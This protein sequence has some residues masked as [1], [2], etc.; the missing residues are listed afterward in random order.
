MVFI[1]EKTLRDLEFNL[2]IDQIVPF[3]ISELGAIEIQKIHPINDKEERLKALYKVDEYLSSFVNENRIPNHTFFNN[4]DAIHLLGIE[5]TFIEAKELLEIEANL[6]TLNTLL[7]FFKKFKEIYPVLYA[8]S[9]EVIFSKGISILINAKITKYGT[10][11]DNASSLLKSIRKEIGSIRSQIGVSFERALKRYQNQHYLD[12]IKE[13]VVE[14]KRVL[15]VQAM[16][17]KK[18]N[19]SIMG[20]SK[21]GSIVFIAPQA[22]LKFTRELQHLELEEKEEVI[23]IL[24]ELT[25]ELR[26]YRDLFIVHQQYLTTLDVV[27]A[28]AKYAQSINALL[29]IITKE[30]KIFLREAY[31]PILWQQNNEKNISTIPQTIELNEQQQIIV[32]SGPNAGGKSIT[33]KT[34][35]L[36]QVMLQSGVL[37]PVHEKSEFSF[38]DTI[39]TDI[40]DNQSIENQ[41]STYS[42]RLKNMQVFL[43]KCND[44]TLFL[45]DEFGTGSDPEL[46]GA[47]AEIFL[48][49]FYHKKSFGVITTHYANLKALADELEFAVN[50]NMQFDK[51]SLAPLFELVTGQAGSSFTFEVARQNGIPYSLINRAKKKVS[52][53]KVRLDKTISKLQTERNKLQR[54]SLSLEKEKDL[55]FEKKQELSNK[56]LRVQD[57]LEQFQTLYDSNQKM[58]QYGRDINELINRYFQTNNKKQLT[59]EF[60]KWIQTERVKFTK[61]N[62]PKK[63]TRKQKQVV[64]KIKQKQ[65][66][67]LK[68]TEKE[69]LK[70][71]K[72]VRKEKSSKEAIIA[73]KKAEYQFKIGD[74]V[75]LIDGRA[76]GTI[77]RVQRKKIVINYGIFTTQAA[78]DQIELVKAAK[79]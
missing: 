61:K 69:V 4:S 51:R 18:V 42:Y 19:G 24:K 78:I 5:N 25:D 31:H 79:P 74:V 26:P 38:F 52:S 50:A 6:Q 75:R 10:V 45:I 64:E 2:V 17:R 46:G 70:A 21:T 8:N 44:S 32:I 41:L 47:L 30:K 66:Q 35:G 48:E 39:L 36:L 7:R 16:H 11:S 15:A 34:I 1:T 55:A 60:N 58:L 65:Q 54:K 77:E 49:E 20:T 12:A 43:R 23:R 27:A 72:I 56:Q 3:A 68:Q 33:L 62:P 28:K 22:T 76:Q 9:Q 63:R 57:K 59:A 13:S 40:G 14:G 73:K 71:V 67:K 37:L 53:S 29:P